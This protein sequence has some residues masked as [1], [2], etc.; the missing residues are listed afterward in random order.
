LR[1]KWE[2]EGVITNGSKHRMGNFKNKECS[3]I[4]NVI[5]GPYSFS[6]NDT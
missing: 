6:I 5:S 1:G 3:G 4:K 2:V